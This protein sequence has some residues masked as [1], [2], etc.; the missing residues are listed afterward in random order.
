MAYKRKLDELARRA[1]AWIGLTQGQFYGFLWLCLG[2]LGIGFLGGFIG[3]LMPDTQNP[4]DLQ[5][6]AL[7]VDSLEAVENTRYDSTSPSYRKTDDSNPPAEL[8]HFDPNTVSHADMLRLGFPDFL[9]KRIENYR[10]KGGKFR[11]KA[12]LQKIYGFPPPLYQKI[13]PYI[14]LQENTSEAPAENRPA[15]IPA[16]SQPFELNTADT[17]QLKSISGI[18]SKRANAIVSYREKLGGFHSYAQLSEIWALKNAP[19]V[20]ERIKQKTTLD[21]KLI[22]K[23][24]I[25]TADSSVLRKHPYLGWKLAK[26]IFLYRQNHGKFNS[27]TDLSKMYSLDAATI[28]KILPYLSFE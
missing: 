6:L 3:W 8:F 10:S 1:E 27:A 7:W 22:R 4:G 14:A 17:N 25:N 16:Q 11:K 21:P 23:I 28:E 9:A 5:A 15:K 19:E 24:S 18:A 26:A 12:D 13:E 2:M 20:I